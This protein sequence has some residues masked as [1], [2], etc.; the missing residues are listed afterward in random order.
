MSVFKF[1]NSQFF[2]RPNDEEFGDAS[3]VF[4]LG[5]DSDHSGQISVTDNGELHLISVSSRNTGAYQCIAENSVG[6]ITSHPSRL[7]VSRK[8]ILFINLPL[9]V[10]ACKNCVVRKT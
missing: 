9:S 8:C 6:R 10:F 5:R 3:T 4:P 1:S 7:M 2:D